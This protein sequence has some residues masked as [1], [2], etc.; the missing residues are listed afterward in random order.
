MLIVG[1]IYGTNQRSDLLTCSLEVGVA[2]RKT[3]V[4]IPGIPGM[5]DATEVAVDE[6]TER[7]TDLKL[8]DGTEIR[9]KTVVLAV[10]RLEGQYDPE[11]NPMY[12]IKANQIMTASAPDH[13][14]KGAGGSKPH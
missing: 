6:A 14:R 8:A 13:L 4:Q 2:E 10:I 5:V 12:Q 1:I 11:G 3:K 7:W 9:I